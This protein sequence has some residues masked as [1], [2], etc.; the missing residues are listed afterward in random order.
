[1]SN[2]WGVAEVEREKD[3]GKWM[4]DLL[5][6]SP[7]SFLM[8]KAGVVRD[9]STSYPFLYVPFYLLHWLLAAMNDVRPG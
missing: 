2:F 4:D 7:S 9:V 1:V 5:N 6:L 3:I 8:G